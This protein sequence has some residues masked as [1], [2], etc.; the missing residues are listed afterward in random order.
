MNQLQ[1]FNNNVFGDLPVIVV[2]GVE[3]FGATEAAKA[4]TFSD[5]YKAITNHV[6]EEDSTV[7][8]VLTDG[9]IQQKKFIS[10]SGFYSLIFGASKQ[11]N[12]AEIKGKAKAYKKWVTSEV[13]P[14]IRKTGGYISNDDLF[15]HTYL[16]FADDQT[17]LLFKATLTTVRHQNELIKKQQQE[18]EHKE[19]VIIGL[20]D[21]I[22][23]ASKRQILNR[24]VRKNGMGKMQQRWNELYK[25][26]EM[27]YH[28]NLQRSLDSYNTVNKPKLKNKLDY[29]DKV[30]C[31]IP[32]LYEI[33]AKLYE[34][35]V[36]ELVV[37]L[38]QVN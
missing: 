4:L 14:T 38:Y 18:I 32:E 19:Q 35:D 27:K 1:M 15:I 29:I 28:L 9:G 24:V 20:V 6:D 34:N 36:K 3:W 37:E 13:L 21:E 7:H 11:G 12:N 17:Q 5:P 22:D 33:A 2:D 25:Q 30:L 10:E 8:P 23:L 26:F 16:P 31:R